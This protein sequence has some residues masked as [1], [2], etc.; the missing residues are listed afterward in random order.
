[1]TV[2]LKMRRGGGRI[3]TKTEK[4]RKETRE[5]GGRGGSEENRRL[6]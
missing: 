5:Q 2:I 4:G 1:M 6:R 3:Y